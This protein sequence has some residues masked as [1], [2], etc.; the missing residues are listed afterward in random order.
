MKF[1][2]FLLISFYGIIIK[3]MHGLRKK[4]CRIQRYAK[5]EKSITHTRAFLS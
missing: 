2:F 1:I 4:D 5:K 3:G